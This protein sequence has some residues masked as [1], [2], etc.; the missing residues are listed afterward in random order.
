MQLICSEDIGN[1][2]D[3][4]YNNKNNCYHKKFIPIETPYKS[5]INI[6]IGEMKLRLS[7]HRFHVERYTGKKGTFLQ[8]KK[9]TELLYPNEEGYVIIQ[10]DAEYEM[11]DRGKMKITKKNDKKIKNK[12]YNKS[13][14][15]QDG[16]DFWKVFASFCCDYKKEHNI[17]G[18]ANKEQLKNAWKKL[19]K[20][21]KEI[22][23]QKNQKET[24]IKS[25]YDDG[26]SR[27]NNKKRQ[28]IN[29]K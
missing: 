22:Y 8:N 26:T 18:K 15:K 17:R 7:D 24:K 14:K 23:F 3:D 2:F 12:Q 4:D 11:M 19:D 27:N 16:V 13:E 29:D 25:K 21:K 20:A 1:N 5:Y 28:K 9:T 10:N 6:K